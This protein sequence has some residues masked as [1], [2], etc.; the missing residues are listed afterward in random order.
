MSKS[1]KFAGLNGTLKIHDIVIPVDSWEIILDQ[2][3]SVKVFYE[4]TTKMGF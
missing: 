3:I 1:I 2:Q 4:H